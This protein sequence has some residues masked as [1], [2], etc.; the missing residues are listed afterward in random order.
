MLDMVTRD[1]NSKLE[2]E[3]TQHA[4]EP[5]RREQTQT[6]QPCHASGIKAN[7]ESVM[8][9]TAFAVT[10]LCVTSILR[11]DDNVF[12]TTLVRFVL[13]L[14]SNKLPRRHERMC[15]F[16]VERLM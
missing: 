2:T 6:L 7:G 1:R 11:T 4:Y 13:I 10:N 5:K 15:L 12:A 8:T 16:T 14:R 3:S 9:H